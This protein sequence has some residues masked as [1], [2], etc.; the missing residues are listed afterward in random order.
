VSDDDRRALR[1]ERSIAD[2]MDLTGRTAVVTGAA[3]GIGAAICS[4]LAESGAVVVVADLDETAAR[5]TAA[6]LGAQWSA[7]VRPFGVDVTDSSSVD[8][9][10]EFAD[11]IG[12]GLSIWVNNAGVYP[13]APLADISD[14]DWARTLSVT[15][16]G[17]FYGCRAAAARMVGRA[18][19]PGRVIINM[20]SLSGLRGRKN[21]S[22]YVAAK[23]A[24][25]GLVRSLS[26]E[27]GADGIRVVGVAPSVVDTP[28]MQQR[29][30]EG[31]PEDIKRIETLEAAALA[32]IPLG[33]VGLVDDVARAVLYL[34]SDLS[35]YIT[36]VI[37]PIDGG[38][39]AS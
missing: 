4:R 34:A 18:K 12:A 15:L 21:L 36:G 11:S 25:T 19:L 31:T 14:A 37:L 17:T 7:D 28:G 3:R 39:S 5:Q 16:D 20:S 13:S 24:V 29:R 6:D 30:S 23:H 33:R 1:P 8:R 9:L 35:G 32:M 22:S 26:T 10:A 38:V 2:L 27:L